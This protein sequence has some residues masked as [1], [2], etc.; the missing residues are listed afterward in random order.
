MFGRRIAEKK[1]GQTIVMCVALF[2]EFAAFILVFLN[3]PNNS[4]FGDTHDS[5]IIPTRY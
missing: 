5:A 3:F 4:V 1:W 2:I